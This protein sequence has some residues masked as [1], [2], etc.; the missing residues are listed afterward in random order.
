AGLEGSNIDDVGKE[1]AIYRAHRG[2]PI[3]I[4]GEP[5]RARFGAA[6]E[7]IVVPA[8]HPGLDFILSTVA[9]HLFCYEAALAID[10]TARPLREA[11]AAIEASAAGPVDEVLSR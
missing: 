9:G 2:V 1:I 4:A 3:V 7:V 5:S 8:V 10:A 11:R 6:A